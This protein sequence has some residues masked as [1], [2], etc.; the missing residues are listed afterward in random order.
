MERYDKFDCNDACDMTSSS[1]MMFMNNQFMATMLTSDHFDHDNAHKQASSIMVM[2]RN[3]Q[4]NHDNAY[5]K[6]SLDVTMFANN[7]FDHSD[8]HKQASSVTTM[9]TNNV[10]AT[11]M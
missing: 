4:F 5:K 8:A 9:F 7:P 2:F 10:I 6:A 11:A 3:N 1:A